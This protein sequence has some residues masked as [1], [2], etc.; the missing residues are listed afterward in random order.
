MP[1][2]SLFPLKGSL[3]MQGGHDNMLSTKLTGSHV[4][5]AAWSQLGNSQIS[6]NFY[7][8]Y[9]LFSLLIFSLFSP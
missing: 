3:S 6:H 9:R 5:S 4:L 7:K 8:K 1:P 2:C